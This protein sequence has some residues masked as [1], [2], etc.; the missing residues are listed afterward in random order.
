MFLITC[1]IE[2]SDRSASGKLLQLMNRGSLRRTIMELCPV[3]TSELIPPLGVVAEPL[4]K[5][6]RRT[7]VSKP[8]IQVKGQLAQASGPQAIDQYP[9]PAGGTRIVSSLQQDR[10]ELA[11]PVAPR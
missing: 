1:A 2:E 9:L 8:K 6:V 7:N 4:A 5:L 10:H 3:A 11:R